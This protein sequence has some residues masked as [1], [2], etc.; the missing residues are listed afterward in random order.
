MGPAKAKQ[1]ANITEKNIQ[2]IDRLKWCARKA[3]IAADGFSEELHSIHFDRRGKK[4]LGNQTH[5][6]KCQSTASLHVAAPSPQRRK[7]GEG[8]GAATRRLVDC[9]KQ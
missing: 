6:D 2:G 7:N 1:I 5:P 3:C 9:L 4:G 8:E